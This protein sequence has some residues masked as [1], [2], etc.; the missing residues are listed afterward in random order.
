MKKL[1]TF[2]IIL[3]AGMA[4]FAVPIVGDTDAI[5][6]INTVEAVPQFAGAFAAVTDVSPAFVQAENLSSYIN[7]FE[8]SVSITTI[9]V[10][11]IALY[12]QEVNPF[13]GYPKTA[14]QKMFDNLQLTPE[15]WY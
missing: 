10:N 3:V 13:Y 1:L 6:A 5:S 7:H 12:R 4:L 11:E 2:L 14:A 15:G 8:E 9:N